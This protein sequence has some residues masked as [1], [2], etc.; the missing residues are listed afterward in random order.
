VQYFEPFLFAFFLDAMAE[1]DLCSGL[2]HARV[3]AESAVFLRWINRPAGE[4]FRDL[5]DIFFACSRR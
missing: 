4:D 5:G 3:E 1:N 2:V